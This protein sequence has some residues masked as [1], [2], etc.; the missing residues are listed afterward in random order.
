MMHS[1][2][3]CFTWLCL[4]GVLVASGCG[5]GTGDLSGTVTY[6]GKP[7][8]MGSVSVA[9]GDGIIRAGTIEDDGSYTVSD[10]STGTVKIAV[11]SPDPKLRKV[12][13]KPKS[14]A[15]A[16]PTGDESKWIA[17]PEKYGDFERSGLTFPLQ[18]GANRL[19][20]KL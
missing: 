19:A 20:I 1:P 10:I 9:G 15:T 4:S 6:Q 5:G 7:L 8:R 3:I 11:T 14:G 16:E 13:A 18:P 12:A 17:I 2:T